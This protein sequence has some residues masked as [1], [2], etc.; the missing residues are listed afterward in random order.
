[1]LLMRFDVDK[2]PS[3][4]GLKRKVTQL[5]ERPTGAKKNAYTSS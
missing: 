4:L 5:I 2:R 1:M 3:D